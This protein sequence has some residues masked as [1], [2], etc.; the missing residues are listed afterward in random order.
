[1]APLLNT[2]IIIEYNHLIT[3]FSHYGLNID[4]HLDFFFNKMSENHCPNDGL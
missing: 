4:N 2:L 3:S 1:M